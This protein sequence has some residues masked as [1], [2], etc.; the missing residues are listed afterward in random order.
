MGALLENALA[1]KPLQL[2]RR[3]AHLSDEGGS[4]YTPVGVIGRGGAG[5]E[6]EDDDASRDEY[7][8]PNGRTGEQRRE[9]PLRC[10]IR[11]DRV[12]NIIPSSKTHSSET[13]R[14]GT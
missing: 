9:A 10:A 6:G 13:D 11:T 2:V 8:D 12:L 14:E 1:K 5:G 7:F 4:R 3:Q